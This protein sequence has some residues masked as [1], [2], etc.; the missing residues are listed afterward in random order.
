L[1]CHSCC[2]IV[3]AIVLLQLL[4]HHSHCVISVIALLWLLWSLHHCSHGDQE[5]H[6]VS[7]Q[8][9]HHIGNDTDNLVWAITNTNVC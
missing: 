6:L 7:F 8:V 2:H 3:M 9:T 4:H 5:L 1:L